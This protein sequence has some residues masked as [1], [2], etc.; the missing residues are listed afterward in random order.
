MASFFKF[1]ILLF[2]F[3]CSTNEKKV[4]IIQN[5]DTQIFEKGIKYIEEKN[6]KKV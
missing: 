6:L 2:L 5:S 1:T 3:S 4:E